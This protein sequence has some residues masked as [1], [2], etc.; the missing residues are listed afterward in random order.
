MEETTM[1][2]LT[3]DLTL[4]QEAIARAAEFEV[5]KLDLEELR[6]CLK[7]AIRNDLIQSNII[8]QLAQSLPTSKSRPRLVRQPLS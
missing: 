4:E 3:Y 8:H 5:D 1:P 2:N 6:V 7:Q